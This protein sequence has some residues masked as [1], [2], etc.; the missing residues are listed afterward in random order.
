MD[1]ARV[2]KF[3]CGLGMH[4][5]K[6]YS[7]LDWS[8][9]CRQQL[10]TQAQNPYPFS[11]VIIFLKLGTVPIFRDFSEKRHPFLVILLQKN[12]KFSKFP[13][14]H[15]ANSKIF[16]NHADPYRDFIHEK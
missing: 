13:G 7:D 10:K 12:T 2:L 9:M 15:Y 6:G 1:G 14:V 8:G 5:P 16:E 4:N 3:S 11:G